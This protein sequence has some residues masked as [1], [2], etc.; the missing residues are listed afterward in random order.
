M[1]QEFYS[2]W[3][4]IQIFNPFQVYFCV[5]YQVAFYFHS[6][7]CSFPV[8]PAPFIEE[9]IYLPL[10]VPALLVIDQLTI[11]AWVYFWAFYSIPLIY[12]SVFVPVSYCFDDCSFIVQSEVRELDSSSSTFLSQD[13]FGSLGSFLFPNK[14]KIFLIQFYEKHHR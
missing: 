12:I 8:F 3:P 14:L 10:Y 11:G 2:I 9:T 4:Y 5:Q 7:I 6:F 13:C 1:L